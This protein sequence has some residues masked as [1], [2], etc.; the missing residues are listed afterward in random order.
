M[1]R[2]EA[3]GI[4]SSGEMRKNHEKQPI[5]EG[6]SDASSLPFLEIMQGADLSQ[7][8]HFEAHQHLLLMP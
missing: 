8:V 3:P 7:M 6:F 1:D 2:N 4:Y 5:I